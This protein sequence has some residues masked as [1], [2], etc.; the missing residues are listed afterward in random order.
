M[1]IYDFIAVQRTLLSA[2]QNTFS[3]VLGYLEN[4]LS[5][6]YVEDQIR[7][8]RLMSSPWYFFRLPRSLRNITVAQ[9]G[10]CF[11]LVVLGKSFGLCCLEVLGGQ[12]QH[13]TH[14]LK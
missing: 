11:W 6:V 1:P 8:K 10:L 5:W 13:F 9:R 7:A 2:N 3:L 12:D 14:T 4:L